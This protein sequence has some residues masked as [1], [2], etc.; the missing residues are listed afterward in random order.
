M[1][2]LAGDP[3][4]VDDFYWQN[5]TMTMSSTG[6]AMSIGNSTVV[7]RYLRLG[8]LVIVKVNV[9]IGTTFTAGT[10]VYL[11]SLPFAPVDV[12]I[13]SGYLFDTGT[14]LYSVS[15]AQAGSQVVQLVYQNNQVG[16]GTP[17][18]P[19]SGDEFNF[20]AVCAVA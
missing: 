9:T 4:P 15:V 13:G 6:T 11:F 12:P 17:F 16:S 8:Q 2:Y 3:L 20:V 18:T 1:S 7:S 5:Y 10:G 19:T 14:A